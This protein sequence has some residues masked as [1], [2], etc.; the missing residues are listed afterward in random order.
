MKNKTDAT[1]GFGWPSVVVPRYFDND[2]EDVDGDGEKDADEVMPQI[3]VPCLVSPSS[4]YGSKQSEDDRSEQ[5][6]DDDDYSEDDGPY[7]NS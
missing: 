5:P 1:I 2:E 4:F 6:E 3:L 7:L